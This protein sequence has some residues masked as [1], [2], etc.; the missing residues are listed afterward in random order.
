MKSATSIAYRKLTAADFFH[1]S[2]P[3][4]HDRTGGGQ[5]YIDLA[6]ASVPLHKW[7]EFFAHITPEEMKGGPAWDVK[8]KSCGLDTSQIVRIATRANQRGEFRNVSIR[9]Q[10][11]YSRSSN[12]IFAWHPDRTNFPIL[13]KGVTSSN[14]SELDEIVEGLYVFIIRTEDTEYWAGYLR[15]GVAGGE[16]YNNLE[17]LFTKNEGLINLS[18]AMT[19]DESSTFPKFSSSLKID[20]DNTEAVIKEKKETSK[21]TP[22][23]KTK[24]K[25]EIAFTDLLFEDDLANKEPQIKERTSKVRQRNKKAVNALKNLYKTCQIT[26]NEYV[27]NKSDGEPYLEV[28]HLI[29]LG[30]GGADH[31]ANLVVIS[32]HIHRMLHYADVSEIDLGKISDN[33]LPIRINNEDYEITWKPEHFELIKKANEN[34]NS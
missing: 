20:E 22:S 34:L 31:P 27:F 30:E 8:I 4:G 11:L 2:K 9:S 5:S 33:K 19:F 16:G 21:P 28:H 10:K 23:G 3:H 14:A 7:R 26:D 32:A 25:K 13:P 24:P 18:N 15:K 29:P 1:T 17:N 12:R 6:G